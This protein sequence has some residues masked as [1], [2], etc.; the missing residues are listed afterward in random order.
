MSK[1]NAQYLKESKFSRRS[2]GGVWS[3][4]EEVQKPLVKSIQKAA[5]DY[6]ASVG[7][8]EATRWAIDGR[9]RPSLPRAFKIDPFEVVMRGAD[10]WGFFSSGTLDTSSFL[11]DPPVL[12]NTDGKPQ[13]LLTDDGQRVVVAPGSAFDAVPDDDLMTLRVNGRVTYLPGALKL[14]DPNPGAS[15]LLSLFGGS[16]VIKLRTDRLTDPEGDEGIQPARF[17]AE[18]LPGTTTVEQAKPPLTDEDGH[19]TFD[20]G[21]EAFT[22]GDT[23]AETNLY[24]VLSPFAMWVITNS[25]GWKPSALD[26]DEGLL[27][28]GSGFLNG[29]GCI[30]VFRDPKLLWADG[31]CKFKAASY[32]GAHPKSQPMRTTLEPGFGTNIAAYRRRSQSLPNFFRAC[33]DAVGVE[34][35]EEDRVV[36]RIE[37]HGS[38]VMMTFDT[39]YAT[40]FQGPTTRKVGDRILKGESLSGALSL[41]C[42]ETHGVDWFRNRPWG[43]VGVEARL[44]WPYAD[45]EI[46]LRDLP[47]WARS[48]PGQVGGG[49][50]ASLE[51]LGSNILSD[52]LWDEL[53]ARERTAGTNWA[54]DTFGFVAPGQEMIVNPLEVAVQIA[55]GWVAAIEGPLGAVDPVRWNHLKDFIE[56]SKPAGSI[57]IPGATYF[58]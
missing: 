52:A 39:G 27:T 12:I 6:P 5:T 2:S 41:R 56:E 28:E 46:K 29:D 33:C 7:L 25:T 17:S 19:L 35:S 20:E 26:T 40:H 51:T 44:F 47:G 8:R 24:L 23:V 14:P 16:R 30:H 36:R 49:L 31:V 4:I 43:L 1:F 3:R 11:G 42:E 58:F 38:K 48:Y 21:G 37:R 53:A 34:V 55:G 18:Q 15:G 9:S 10:K 50:R 45:K 54:Y 32:V 22:S 13:R 57:I